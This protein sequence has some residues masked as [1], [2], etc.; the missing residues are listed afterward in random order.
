MIKNWEQR[1][2]ET[3][4]SS[5]YGK[6]HPMDIDLFY[7]SEDNTLILG[8]IKNEIGHLSYGQKS[9]YEKLCNGWKYNAVFMYIVHNNFVETGSYRIDIPKCKVKYIYYKVNGKIGWVE[10][11]SIT[12]GDILEKFGLKRIDKEDN[13]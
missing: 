12:C 5:M 6:K 2:V 10:P 8:E 9:L 3:D 11:L 13:L 1:N 7:L 4:F